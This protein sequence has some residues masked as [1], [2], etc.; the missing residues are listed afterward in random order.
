MMMTEYGIDET[1]GGDNWDLHLSYKS[2]QMEI[3]EGQASS[4]LSRMADAATNGECA[5][6]E[7]YN[8]THTHEEVL[9]LWDDAIASAQAS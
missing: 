3:A 9:A 4:L 2:R 5:S 8:D 1:D 6:I 7:S